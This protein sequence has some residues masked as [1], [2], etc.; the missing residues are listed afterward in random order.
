MYSNFLPYSTLTSTT[1]TMRRPAYCVTK[2]M[3]FT[4][5]Q[6]DSLEF[7]M[8][9]YA[10]HITGTHSFALAHFIDISL[11][12]GLNSD[13]VAIFQSFKIGNNACMA[14]GIPHILSQDRFKFS[15][16]FTFSSS[17]LSS[18]KSNSLWRRAN[19]VLSLSCRHSLPHRNI[20]A[21]SR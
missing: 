12:P 1:R 14:I 3:I 5:H 19:R 17:E 15:V 11:A 13:L 2:L 18:Q 9:Q 7:F 20:P 4:G 16:C 10:P 8:L 21:F 6:R